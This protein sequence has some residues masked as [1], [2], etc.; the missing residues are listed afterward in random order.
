[1]QLNHKLNKIS[2]Q[3]Y[4]LLNRKYFFYVY[5]SSCQ[6]FYKARPRGFCLVCAEKVENFWELKALVHSENGSEEGKFAVR[7][8]QDGEGDRRETRASVRA[9]GTAS[10]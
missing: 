10:N 9:R 3:R 4:I 2:H 1:M 7:G 6:L 5:I 8:D